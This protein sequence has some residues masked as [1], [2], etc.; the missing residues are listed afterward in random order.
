[1][2]SFGFSIKDIIADK[3]KFEG[4]NIIYILIKINMIIYI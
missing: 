1:M 2:G 3:K 4:I